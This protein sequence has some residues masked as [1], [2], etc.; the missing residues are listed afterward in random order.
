MRII[1]KNGK[2]VLDYQPE[3][4]LFFEYF[5]I[6]PHLSGLKY[7]LLSDCSQSHKDRQHPQLIYIDI[8]ENSDPNIHYYTTLYIPI[9]VSN[10]PRIVCNINDTNIS[11]LELLKIRRYIITNKKRL[12]EVANYK[13]S[14]LDFNEYY[15]TPYQ[16]CMIIN[17]SRFKNEKFIVE[18]NCFKSDTG[19]NNNI[20]VDDG[21]TYLKSGHENRIKIQNNYADRFT[22]NDL[23]PM[24]IYGDMKI[25]VPLSKVKISND[26][27]NKVRKWVEY[28]INTLTDKAKMLN[29]KVE[30]SV[31]L[32]TNNNPIYPNNRNKND[33]MV[34]YD[35]G[36]GYKLAT[37][38]NNLQNLIH[39]DGH[40]IT[41][42][43]YK[44]FQFFQND[45]IDFED[46]KGNWYKMNAYGKIIG[47]RE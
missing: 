35:V 34:L 20:W 16:H 40:F 37:N 46:L 6:P 14:W 29:F 47:N 17:E 9:T 41:N 39:K 10:N 26:D 22:E 21:G 11:L 4:E 25:C 18:T 43:W 33:Y 2:R 13:L 30:N 31:K 38:N 36:C 44:R 1:E 23:I 27:I 45:V 8:E 7:R 24:S 5:S 3:P 19:L 32:D 42:T 12:I 28:N 15:S